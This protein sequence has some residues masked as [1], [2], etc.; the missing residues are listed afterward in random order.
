MENAEIAARLRSMARMMAILG[1][2]AF[3]VR[4]FDNGSRTVKQ[5]PE[6]LTNAVRQSSLERIP[7]IGKGIAGVIRDLVQ[8]GRSEM[9]VELERLVPA[10]IQEMATIPGLGPKKIQQLWTQLDIKT[11]GELEYACLENRLAKLKGFGPQLQQQVLETLQFR[12]RTSNQVLLDQA[13]AA[14]EE[15]QVRLASLESVARVEPTGALRRIRETIDRY[16]FLVAVED[17]EQ[18]TR[19]VQTILDEGSTLVL[20]DPLEI[21]PADGPVVLIHVSDNAQFGWDWLRT[22]GSNEHLTALQKRAETKCPDLPPFSTRT[23]TAAVAGKTETDLYAALELPAVP[24]EMREG[25]ELP[26][27][28]PDLVTHT[29]IKGFFHAHSTWSDGT[30][31]LEELV[32]TAR[33]LGY[34]YLGISEH[35][36]AAFYAGGLS[37][38]QV[39]EQWAEIDELNAKYP[40]FHIFRGIESDILADGALDYED[41]ILAQ[42]DFVIAS[43]HNQFNLDIVK[44]TDRIIRALQSPF[45][46]MLGHPTGRL[47]LSRDGYRID[48]PAIIEAAGENNKLIE[49]NSTIQRFDLD[50]R[51]LSLARSHGVR[52]SINPD[53]HS[54]AMIHSIPLG[55]RIARKGGLTPDEVL[56]TRDTREVAA[57]L[58]QHREEALSQ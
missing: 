21:Q 35:S 22:T 55:V 9:E 19:E 57:F 51:W 36:P 24:P 39:R 43:I 27:I 1:E 33:G 26:E 32:Q 30:T 45:T 29:D 25:S 17:R 46:T 47:L 53:A 31:S 11:L 38:E 48:M 3:K 15:W 20:A 58:R 50:W 28:L 16:T 14:A 34:R 10:G 13:L 2:N 5:W 52:V 42:F 18:F 49:I 8:K 7:G 56:N 37:V 54:T 4:A 12:K 6:P 44:Q 23:D 41:E 40:D